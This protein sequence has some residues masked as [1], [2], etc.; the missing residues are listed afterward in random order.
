MKK[1]LSI[2]LL[3][4]AVAKH[5][6]FLSAHGR[7]TSYIELAVKFGLSPIG[8]AASSHM[9]NKILR[10]IQLTDMKAG[11]PLRTVAVTSLKSGLPGNGY[12]R[13]LGFDSNCDRT[14][15]YQQHVAMAVI[16][17]SQVIYCEIHIALPGPAV[18]IEGPDCVQIRAK[19]S[20][21]VVAIGLPN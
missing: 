8:L 17:Y 6:A 13:L 14:S 21:Q 18:G 5:L 9:L 4:A 7:T 20:S 11:R 15:I 10:A 2:A 3:Y 12:Y 1:N 19:S 16:Y